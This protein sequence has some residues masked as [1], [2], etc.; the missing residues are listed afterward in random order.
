MTS[1]RIRRIILNA[2]I[3]GVLNYYYFQIKITF[4]RW[5]ISGKQKT[6][7]CHKSIFS[8][9]PMISSA[10]SPYPPRPPRSWISFVFQRSDSYVF[11]LFRRES[12]SSF[13]SFYFRHFAEA[14][15]FKSDYSFMLG[16]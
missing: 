2:S 4:I 15:H 5:I 11:H 6:L 1:F 8:P 13:R 16:G 14:L 9:S 3:V 7:L 10:P 12:Q